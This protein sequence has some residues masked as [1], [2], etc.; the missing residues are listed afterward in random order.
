MERCKN[1]T[2]VLM[3][4][5]LLLVSLALRIDQSWAQPEDGKGV[6]KPSKNQLNNAM[7]ATAKQHKKEGVGR[8]TT[9]D[10]RTAA[11]RR[12]TARKAAAQQMGNGGA[13]K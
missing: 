13:I 6:T 2:L 5:L 12:N 3:C 7:N 10:D 8:S 1:I 11:A 4:A 9:S